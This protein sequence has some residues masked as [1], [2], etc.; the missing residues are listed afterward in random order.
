MQISAKTVVAKIHDAVDR[1][2]RLD[3]QRVVHWIATL[4]KEPT[5]EL[6]TELYSVFLDESR[7]ERSYLEQQYAGTLLWH[8]RPLCPM[9]L[10]TALRGVLRNYN[11]SVE[12]LPW[13]FVGYFGMEPVN[14]A[15]EEL[16]T[17]DMS[18]GE[19]ESLRTLR[20]WVAS[21]L[22]CHPVLSDCFQS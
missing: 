7:G 6:F 21:Y 20:Y 4:R 2:G 1:T 13:Y 12:E 11:L 3:R 19:A 8:V 9:E 17:C 5:P 15:L 16:Q 18:E 22:R 10:R 14:Q